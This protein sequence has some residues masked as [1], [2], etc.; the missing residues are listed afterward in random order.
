MTT[1]HLQPSLCIISELIS[2]TTGHNLHAHKFITPEYNS[3]VTESQTAP[4]SQA[5]Q[6]QG[7]DEDTGEIKKEE[8]ESRQI[9]TQPTNNICCLIRKQPIVFAVN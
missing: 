3:S 2:M 7:E 4:G 8:Q 5:P 9:K 6:N 1:P